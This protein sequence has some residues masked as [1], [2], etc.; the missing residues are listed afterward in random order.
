MIG[1]QWKI[2]EHNVK[3]DDLGVPLFQETTI[4]VELCRYIIIEL[5]DGSYRPSFNSGTPHCR[6]VVHHRNDVFFKSIF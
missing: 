1:L 4:Y 3:M 5:A 2:N 6:I